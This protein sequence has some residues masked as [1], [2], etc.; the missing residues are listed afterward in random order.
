MT[1]LQSFVLQDRRRLS[2]IP[3]QIECRF[4][5]D[6]SNAEEKKEY[7][8]L[9]LDLSQEGA[10]LS[11]TFLPAQQD[12]V[13][14]TVEADCLPAPLT[15][16]GKVLR[17]GEMTRS[18]T[19]EVR[20]FGVE[21]E[22]PP[23]EL[24]R[25][26]S[27]LSADRRR[28]ARISTQVECRFM[29]DNKEYE[30]TIIDMSQEGAFL[31]STFLPNKQSEIFINIKADCLDAPLRLSGTVARSISGKNG[32]SDRFGVAYDTPPSSI[33]RL[34]STASFERRRT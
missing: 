28:L 25:L 11:S 8:A 32:A 22:N 19:G 13:F 16:I 5:P 14:I 21:F 24:L 7:E 34:I 2:R 30:A 26:L 23:Q 9:M 6:G 15:I 12:K 10:F 18:D 20:Q 27:S 17:G 3:T 33:R 29:H 1:V 4:R 31:S